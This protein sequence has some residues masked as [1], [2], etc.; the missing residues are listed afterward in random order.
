MPL[1]VIAVAVVDVAAHDLLLGEGKELA[2]GHGVRAL[3]RNDRCEGPCESRNAMQ[4]EINSQQ[5]PP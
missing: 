1:T 2:R 4:R 5:L 3:N